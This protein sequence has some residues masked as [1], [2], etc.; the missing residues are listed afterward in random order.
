M[1]Y[2]KR[3]EGERLYLSP[4]DPGEAEKL[5][6]W[7][8]DLDFS[9]L[10]GQA[11]EMFPLPKVRQSLQSMSAAGHHFAIVDRAAE[12]FVGI[13]A[14]TG[15]NEHHRYASLVISIGDPE[16]RHKGYGQEAVRLL[17]HYGFTELHL[18]NV[19]LGVYEYNK[20][21][22]RCY[23]KCG[24]REIGRRRKAKLIAGR[25]YDIVWMDMLADDFLK[26]GAD[27]T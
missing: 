22:I 21:A 12:R 17:L 18:H 26:E 25:R 13:C 8:N 4:P 10:T 27:A 3:L 6:E 5:A 11:A 14:L 16:F 2:Y 19:E 1:P 24:F 23:E 15:V 7:N 20:A 9:I